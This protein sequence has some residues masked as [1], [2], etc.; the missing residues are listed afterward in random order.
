MEER[1]TGIKLKDGRVMRM[2]EICSSL[3]AL[4]RQENFQDVRMVC[5]D[6]EVRGA[7]L[8]LAL[9]F[10]HME[11]V[12]EEREEEELV[13]ILPHMQVAEVTN[14]LEDFLK[15]T[16][17]VEVKEEV[18]S[19]GEAEE[20][21]VMF[22]TTDSQEQYIQ[23]TMSLK[24]VNAKL[25]IKLKEEEIEGIFEVERVI[26]KRRVN[27]FDEYLVKWKGYGNEED[28]TWELAWN[29]PTELIAEF[30]NGLRSGPAA[31]NGSRYVPHGLGAGD[32]PAAVALNPAHGPWSAAAL[33]A[34]ASGLGAP[35]GHL[36]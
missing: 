8:V 22:A 21:D 26:G 19:D 32:P 7:R 18:G 35:S 16:P 5:Q 23:E 31:V 2:D 4:S 36:K 14:R 20:D 11:E 34:K 28:N 15:Y 17:K 6:G 10:P 3:A 29:L 24:E 25:E 27:G 33:S 9:A 1:S 13:L 12:M 30:E